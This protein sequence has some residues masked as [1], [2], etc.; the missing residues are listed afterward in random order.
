MQL[1][2]YPFIELFQTPMHKYIFDVNTNQ[3]IRVS[4]ELY[5]YFKEWRKTEKPSEN[6][7]ETINRKISFLKKQGFLSENYPTKMKHG[8]SDYLE[9]YLQKN[10]EQMTLQITQKCN[11]RCSYCTYA[12][13][14]FDYQRQHSFKEMDL[15]TALSA[16]D[17]L[18]EHSVGRPDVCIGF[19][20]G[21]PLL[22]FDLLE[23]VVNY[24]K[25][26][27]YGKELKFTVTTN[28]S[29]L[30][31]E[32]A[33][34]L[35]D[36]NFMTMIS[37]DGA[38]S[39]HNLSRKFAATG[40]GT[41]D[42]IQ[43]NLKM[44]QQRLPEFYKN[45]SFNIVIDPR[46]RCDEMH[47]MFSNDPLFENV[48]LQSTLIDDNF[49]IEKVIPEDIYL[50]QNGV[51][52]FKAY[53]AVLG[54]YPQ[55]AASRVAFNQVASSI[56][57]IEST[58]IAREKL[59]SELTHSGPCVPGQKRLFVDVNG[60]FFPCERV[61]ETSDAMRIG[62]VKEGIDYDKARKLLNI[63]ELTGEE[64]KKCWAI[65][66]CTICAKLCDNNGELSRDLKLSNCPSSKVTVADSFLSYLLF[67]E[68]KERDPINED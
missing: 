5:D 36:N 19:Y 32:K 57:R 23:T 37:L 6:V 31:Y 26:V 47:D 56:Q 28:A 60:T 13:K 29:L 9:H 61:S 33:K 25:K 10:I 8:M 58:L 3:F 46:F 14:D 52:E 39:I 21:E 64:C 59:P 22:Q 17:F 11:F 41:F 30:T 16:V 34:F 67:K 4:D 54:R 20:G 45:L 66:H 68:L 63:C 27:M 42:V 1:I 2:S 38:P 35:A 50:K 24:A 12:P 15:A 48:A 53:M 40:E 18:R 49:N 51:H 65:S 7:A 62:S 44:L 43:A 55:K